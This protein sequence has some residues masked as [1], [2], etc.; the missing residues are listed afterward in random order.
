[1]GFPERR[2]LIQAGK[3]SVAKTVLA[4]LSGEVVGRASLLGLNFYVANRLG[5]EKYG[6][7]GILIAVASMFQPLADLGLTH[8]ALRNL[9]EAGSGGRFP[10]FVALKIMGSAGFFAFLC[11]WTIYDGHESGLG[12]IL[13]GTL[14]LLTTW[15]DFFRQILRARRQAV[16]ESWLRLVFFGGAVL[17]MIGMANGRPVPETALA[18]LALAPLFLCLGYGIALARGD[19][20]FQPSLDGVRGFLRSEGS[21]A[22]G[23]IAY[24]F[25]VASIMRL[26]VWM[27]NHFLGAKETGVWL[28]AYNMVYAGAFLAQGLASIAIPRLMDRT[29]PA[30]AVLFKIWRLQAVL[31][32]VLFAGVA[33]AGP[34]VFPLLFRSRDFSHAT[35]L[36]PLLGAMLAV[37]SLIVL[38][39]HLFLVA[40]RLWWFL[41]LLL[42]AV[43]VKAALG[44]VLVPRMGLQG[45]AWTGLLSEGPEM[46]VAIIW[47]SRLYLGWRRKTMV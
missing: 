5:A 19:L 40:G 45:M 27:S 29:Q 30:G 8:L 20:V 25:L 37:S 36:L 17:G 10:L 6:R 3:S 33:L 26:D 15:G 24:L 1:M 23:S 39:Y 7:L 43:A 16:Q 9:S 11:G 38:A 42:A 22:A 14:I 4:T 41:S 31:A 46:V 12:F 44:F 13:A 34:V 28:S 47:G 35:A 32:I 2:F 18:C 21:I